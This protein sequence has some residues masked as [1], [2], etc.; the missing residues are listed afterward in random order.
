MIPLLICLGV[1]MVLGF[2]INKLYH[3]IKDSEIIDT[4][5]QWIGVAL[6]FLGVAF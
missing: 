5:L 3:T 6:C 4:G 2:G 1:G